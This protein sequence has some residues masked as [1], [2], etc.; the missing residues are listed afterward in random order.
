VTRHE[1]HARRVIFSH[2]KPCR[3][4]WPLIRGG[5]LRAKNCYSETVVETLNSSVPAEQHT[6]H[7]DR[8]YV[9]DDELFVR[10]S[11]SLLARS[12]GL[13]CDVYVSAEEFAASFRPQGPG[14]LVVD[15]FLLGRS[16]FSLLRE[17]SDPEFLIPAIAIS[18]TADV[19][20]ALRAIQEGAVTFLNKDCEK[21][22][23]SKAISMC[24]R[25]A[26]EAV[27]E[28][29]REKP[30]QEG[31]ERLSDS[32]KVVLDYLI[33]GMPNRSIAKTLNV[34][35]RTLERRR[36]SLLKKL[37]AKTAAEAAH[38]IGLLE[39]ENSILRR[40]WPVPAEL[41]AGILSEGDQTPF[42]S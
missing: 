28:V 12:M 26:N 42:V 31:L 19:R 32:E 24:L 30:V 41:L 9:V 13:L 36:A 34:S 38:M 5:F 1:I 16:G 4:F 14:C 17:Y 2:L 35:E 15:L 23:L 6:P 11:V 33:Q 25:L 29:G 3:R 7:E 37:N 40:R 21:H 8:V 20:H 18:G 22:E 39:R 10:E 27:T